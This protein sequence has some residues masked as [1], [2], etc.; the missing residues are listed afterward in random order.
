MKATAWKTAFVCV[1]GGFLVLTMLLAWAN[2]DPSQAAPPEAPSVPTVTTVKPERKALGRVIEQPALV[3]AFEQA[4]LHARITGYV[5]KVHV[6][7]GD[8]VKKGQVLADLVVPEMEAELL[9]QKALVRQAEAGVEQARRVVQAAEA[10]L[11]IAQAQVVEVEAGVKRAQANHERWQAEYKRLEALVGNKL[12]NQQTL[13]EARNKLAAAKAAQEEAEA[14]VKVA[15]AARE[16]MAARRAKAQ[17]DLKAAEAGLDV[18]R[19]GM[20]RVEVLQQHLQVRAPFDGVVVKRTAVP[21]VLAQPVAGGKATSLFVVAGI[22][23]VRIVV[24]VPEADAARFKK[25]AR[26]IIRFTILEGQEFEGKV[27]RTAWALDP[28]ARTLRA[29]IDFSNPEGK[30]WPGM[31]ATV[32]LPAERREVWTLRAADVVTQGDQTFCY[33]VENGKAIRTPLQV[34]R[35]FDGLVEVL[36]KQTKPGKPDEK[37]LWEDLTGKEDIVQSNLGLLIDGQEVRV[38]PGDKPKDEG[39]PKPEPQGAVELKALMKARL[40]ATQKAYEEAVEASQQLIQTRNL[41]IPLVK[42]EEVYTWSVRWLNAQRDLSSKKDDQVAALKG[43]LQR[44]K[45]LQEQVARLR[46]G[47]VV[48]LS[49]LQPLA[50]ESY[51][52]EAELWLAQEKAKK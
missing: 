16:E 39:A 2:R 47:G 23:P 48:S 20:Q 15:A 3:E 21:G 46:K 44:M 8:R 26:T 18:A 51:L 36:K 24:Q 45:E 50:V 29:E 37:G 40:E 11:A 28:K 7:I 34:G 30:F 33:R 9:H 41:T 12:V 13:D 25:D 43:H 22:D 49:S 14:K 17:A 42:S 27:A 31:Y 5:Q 52:V 38:V 6:D 4:E 1:L 35:R 19:A 10:A 32:A